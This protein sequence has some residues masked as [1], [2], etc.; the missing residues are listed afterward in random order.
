VTAASATRRVVVADDEP[1]ARE[2]LRML[3]ARH[4][5]YE[6]VAECEH[7]AEAVDT[8]VRERPHLVL[9][10][11]RMPELS[12]IEVAEA[13][14]AAGG[15][16]PAVVFVTAYE[17]YALRAFEVSALD[18]LLQPVDAE[19]LDRAL[20]RVEQRREAAPAIQPELRAFLQALERPDA[21]PQRFVV[22]DAKGGLYFVRAADIDWVDA[23]GNYVRLHAGGHAHLVRDTMR[24]FE[25]KLDPATFVRV[26][27]S[28]IV[29][30]D[31]IARLEPYSHGEYVITMRD[32]TRLRTSRAHSGR[33]FELLR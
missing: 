21:Y 13:I 17:E 25:G 22:R 33:L 11:M 16:A 8:I 15:A 1:L 28:A 6:I 3:L 19:R 24:A 23:Q 7:G 9:L 14:D 20:A 32:G 27:R 5:A 31:R 10:D 18:Y 4:P 2:R 29:N 26:H 30:L 12:G